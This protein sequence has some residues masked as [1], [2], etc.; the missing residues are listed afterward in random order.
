MKKMLEDED[1][2]ELGLMPA[3]S[4]NIVETYIVNHADIVNISDVSM[5]SV[6][7]P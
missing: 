7:E 4:S 1:D 3:D 2:I 6:S 5:V